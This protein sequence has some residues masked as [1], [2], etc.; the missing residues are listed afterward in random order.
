MASF[1]AFL[2]FFKQP[3][4]EAK[5]RS[6]SSGQVLPFRKFSADLNLY[7]FPSIS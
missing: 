7:K 1:C 6:G 5:K 3:H 2:G 4:A